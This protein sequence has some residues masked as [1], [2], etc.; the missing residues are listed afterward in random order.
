[1]HNTEIPWS[2]L[3]SRLNS[4]SSHNFSYARCS[5]PLNISMALRWTHLRYIHIYCAGSP[6]LAD[7]T[8]LEVRGLLFCICMY[9]KSELSTL[10][11]NL[12][13]PCVYSLTLSQTE[14]WKFFQKVPDEIYSLGKEKAKATYCQLL[15][16]ILKLA[17][18]CSHSSVGI[19]GHGS[20]ENINSSTVLGL[21]V[22]YQLTVKSSLA[23]LILSL[24]MRTR[25]QLVWDCLS[26][27]Y[28]HVNWAMWATPPCL[29]SPWDDLCF[30]ASLQEIPVSCTRQLHRCCPSIFARLCLWYKS[31]QVNK[32]LYLV[33]RI[34]R[35]EF[36]WLSCLPSIVTRL[37][38]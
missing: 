36:S 34:F 27:Q 37:P 38:I 20:V 31:T 8:S 23:C 32:L 26:A 10:G 24:S 6:D 22:C 4:P 15:V 14:S 1:M 18:T 7:C 16:A 21:S 3:F 30:W 33:Y 35:E 13:L 19:V 25:E 2:L 29:L 5:S 17:L 11:N 9:R 12:P 28:L